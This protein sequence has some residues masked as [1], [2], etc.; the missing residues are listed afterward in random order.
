MERPDR[1]G[2]PE[3]P[4]GFVA[5]EDGGITVLGFFMITAS[6]LIGAYAVDWANMMSARTHLQV[7][8]DAAAHAALV[9]REF[10]TEQDAIDEAI[11]VASLNMPQSRYGEV[12]IDADVEFGDWDPVG[13]SFT[14][15]SGS[16]DAVRVRT[17]RIATRDNPIGTFLLRLVGVDYLS[18]TREAVFESYYPSCLKEGFVAQQIVDLQSNN[19]FTNGFCVHSNDHVSLNSNN[20][21]EPGTV[22]SMPDEN[23]IDLPNSGFETNEGL[24]DALREGSWHIRILKQLADIIEGLRTGDDRYLPDYILG[25]APEVFADR[26]IDQDELIPGRIHT[27]QCN[28]GAAMTFKNGVIVADVVV[29]TDC[30]VK[31]EAGVIVEGA[32][33][34]TTSTDAHSMTASAGLQIGRNDNCAPGGGSQLLTL[35]SMDFPSDLKVYGSQLIALKDIS[36]SANADGVQGA[37]M[38]AGGEISGTSNMSMG[39][40]GTGMDGNF[41]AEYFRLVN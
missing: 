30:K 31:F 27:F 13:Y 21:F 36:F 18:L 26:N 3:L 20:Y 35:G 9:R 41:H 37:A 7:A 8:A 40:C 33:I 16:K 12:L 32:V 4:P 34:A 14:P 15:V 6:M 28:G 1:D 38:V 19:S 24:Q 23:Q 10:A 11:T 17:R 29:V 22:V 39:F 2:A 25:T 5:D